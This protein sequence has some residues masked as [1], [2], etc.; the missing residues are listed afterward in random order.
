M[1]KDLMDILACPVCKGELELRVA[2]EDGDN[3][4]NGSLHCGTCDET[5]P[6]KDSIPNLL[7]PDLRRE[8]A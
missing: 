4:V 2:E 7:P 5:Y 3:V 8:L 1:K 6:I